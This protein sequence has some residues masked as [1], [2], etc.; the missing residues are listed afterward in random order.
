MK[1]KSCLTCDLWRKRASK[2]RGVLIP[3]GMGKC[4]RLE[5]HCNPDIVGGKI[6]EGQ[7][8]NAKN[9]R[10]LLTIADN[11]GRS[12]YYGDQRIFRVK[13]VQTVVMIR[14]KSGWIRLKTDFIPE[15]R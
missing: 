14:V 1:K 15:I 10:N 2:K 7:M 3:G 5:G 4:T 6:G 12:L 11:A 8:M 9:V 13:T